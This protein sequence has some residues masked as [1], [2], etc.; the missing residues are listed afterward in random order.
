MPNVGNVSVTT[1]LFDAKNSTEDNLDG[2]I[3]RR[4]K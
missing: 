4:K 2:Q 1:K 3:M